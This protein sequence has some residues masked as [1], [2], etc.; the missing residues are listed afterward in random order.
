M[1]NQRETVLSADAFLVSETDSKGN[2]IFVN[3]EFCHVAGY[4]REELM[5]QP[6]KVVRHNEMPK[7]A[8]KDLWDTVRQDEVWQGYV[9]NSTKQGGYYWV[10]ATVYPYKNDNKEQCYMSCRRKPSKEDIEN[11]EALYRTMT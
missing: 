3:D 7:A 5:G 1:A 11:S 9:K 6:H 8:F 10:H 2:I 4:T